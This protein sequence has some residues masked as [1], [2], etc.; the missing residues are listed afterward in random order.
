[1]KT[2]SRIL[3]AFTF[4][5]SFLTAQDLSGY[6][7]CID[8]GH[9]GHESDDRNMAY[10]NY[11]ES[12]SNL[13]KAIHLDSLLTHMGATVVLTRHYNGD[14]GSDNDPGLSERA[15][16]ANQCGADHFH[17]IHSNGYN[18]ELNY[19]LMLYPGPTGDP[20]INGI[21]GYP[22]CPIELTIATQMVNQ[23]YS[24]NRTSSKQT[25]G[26]WTFYGTGRPYL[27]V[28]S[29]LIVPGTLS[30]GS[31]HDYQPETWRL[32]NSS[33]HKNEAW[34]IART[35]ALVFD[36]TDFPTRNLAGIVRDAYEKV[37]YTSI[38]SDDSYQPVNQITM[39][40]NPGGKVFTG[41][42]QNNGYFLFDSLETGTYELIATANG[43]YPDTASVTIGSSFFNFKDFKLV[44]NVPP[45]IASS[46]P[47]A[48]F[49]DFP[50]WNPIVITFS[51]PMDTTLTKTA[52]SIS[53]SAPLKF[54]W[55]GTTKLS[56]TSDS[57]GFLTAYT[58]TVNNSALDVLGHALDGNHDGVGGDN[59][60]LSFTTGQ[61]DMTAPKIVS[62]YPI[63]NATGID[64]YPIISIYFDEK[65]DTAALTDDYFLLLNYPAGDTILTTVQHYYVGDRSVVHIVPQQA[66]TPNTIYKPQVLAGLKDLFGNTMLS[67][68]L[69]RFVTGTQTWTVTAIDNLEAGFTDNWWTPTSSGSTT[70]VLG[71]MTT[72][73]ALEDSVYFFGGTGHA[74]MQLKAG[75]D[76]SASAWLLR[77]YLSGGTPRNVTFAAANL[78]QA[79]V[80]GDDS[81]TLFRFAVDDG[82]SFSGHEVSP[83]T[84]IDWIGWKLVSWDMTND[85]TGT[86]IGDGTLNGTLRFDSFQL[87]YNP[88]DTS[89]AKT[90]TIYLDELRRVSVQ[91][92]S[93]ISGSATVTAE[94]F[95]LH[96]NYPNPFNPTTTIAFTLPRESNV[97][98]EIFN[99]L[100]EKVRTLTNERYN[101][102]YWS[103]NWDGTNEAGLQV[104]SG[105]YFYRSITDLGVQV[106]NMMLVK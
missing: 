17:S 33:Y 13:S 78:L 102:G 69:M 105:V 70:G 94:S 47:T 90:C 50:A 97:R 71:D 39:T 1:M 9:G 58:L 82:S 98:I 106:R 92:V 87:S 88:D 76:M 28:F 20:R 66:L 30:E 81:H 26:D 85:T 75:W 15:A 40:L 74:S 43:Y 72:A 54:K 25:A 91:T 96:Q 77:E 65:L 93:A 32:K 57:L 61:E 41:D 79:Y 24:A 3:F 36:S 35:F 64:L 101:S 62:N 73:R 34:A 29:P 84:T 83:W 8:P 10:A 14:S 86:W 89:A 11:W 5:W 27:G 12:E 21:S 59:F 4:V 100:G 42:A 56:I 31:F 7:F 60:T 37:D 55:T 53:P 38:T 46:T 44:S 68:K 67:K 80:F 63:Y 99:V 95:K 104:P 6:K 2:T 48:G 22:S 19:T 16:V 51:R 103:V 18:G 52:V 45:Y 23:I 49:V